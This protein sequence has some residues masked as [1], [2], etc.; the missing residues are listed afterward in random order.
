MTH[1]LKQHIT[2]TEGILHKAITFHVG[3][4]KVLFMYEFS[5]DF[6]ARMLYDP[7]TFPEAEISYGMNCIEVNSLIGNK[8]ISITSKNKTVHSRS[9]MASQHEKS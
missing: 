4:I 5:K 1:A 3:R 7:I 8:K 6:V 9:L 2:D